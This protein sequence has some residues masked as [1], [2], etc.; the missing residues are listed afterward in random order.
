ME[1]LPKTV[2]QA[3]GN[4]RQSAA[5]PHPDADLLAAFQEGAVTA[6]EQ[7]SLLAHFAACAHC[8]EVARLALPAPES[9]QQVVV[10]APAASVWR[11]WLSWAA[12]GPATVVLGSVGIIYQGQHHGSE[13]A[14]LS[15]T[16]SDPSAPV[17]ASG[18]PAA[19]APSAKLQAKAAKKNASTSE[20]AKA[21]PRPLEAAA[22]VPFD[23]QAAALRPKVEPGP[24][25]PEPGLPE[26]GLGMKTGTV[27]SSSATGTK[28]P[29]GSGS[30]AAAHSGANGEVGSRASVSANGGYQSDSLA[31]RSRAMKM[32]AMGAANQAERQTASLPH[33]P[34]GFDSASPARAQWRISPAGE[35]QRGFKG[36]DWQTVLAAAATRFHALAVAGKEVWAGGSEANLFHSTD[37]GA[38]WTR[39]PLPTPRQGQ[40]QGKRPEAPTITRITWDDAL[41]GTVGAD[42][43]T[44][45]TADGGRTWSQQ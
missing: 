2:K 4:S 36:S 17:I 24:G 35:L 30:Q 33:S 3:L 32:K 25:L 19:P 39:V 5:G 14:K 38:S 23:R 15:A 27:F 9:V 10:P 34:S 12:V 16:R 45:T 37:G 29:A 28:E 20:Q 8:R 40:G 43:I 11:R 13:Q 18:M 6:R 7:Q 31:T 42:N 41:H 21:V 44:W 26:A 1:P 22:V